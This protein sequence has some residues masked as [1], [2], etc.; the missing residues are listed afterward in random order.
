MGEDTGPGI[1]HICLQWRKLTYEHVPPRRAYNQ[2][3]GVAHCLNHPL[4]PKVPIG[5]TAR[6]RAGMGVKTLCADCNGM[7][8]VLR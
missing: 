7:T 6:F 4:G 1:C 8:A 2:Y 5:V 3:P